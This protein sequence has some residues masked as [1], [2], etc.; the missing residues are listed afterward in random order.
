V[1]EQLFREIEARY[2]ELKNRVDQGKLTAD[3]FKQELKKM[4]I[5][6]PE[7]RYWMIGG[8]TGG[9][10]I[11][12]NNAWKTANPFKPV[13][14]KDLNH[15][16]EEEVQS[17]EEEKAT[18]SQ[19]QQA[20]VDIEK[21]GGLDDDA[22]AQSNKNDVYKYGGLD[23]SVKPT[24]QKE[25]VSFSQSEH[26]DASNTQTAADFYSKQSETKSLGVSDSVQ[27]QFD[28]E[29]DNHSEL[30]EG[31][32]IKREP[33]ATS[34]REGKTAAPIAQEE[35][36]KTVPCR[37]CGSQIAVFSQFCPICGGNQKKEPSKTQTATV[38]REGEMAI[39]SVHVLSFLIIFGVIG[40][41]F[42]LIVGAAFSI[43]EIGGDLIFQFP[44][45]MQDARGKMPGAFLFGGLGG[46]IGFFLFA[47]SGMALA[48][49]YNGIA[50]IFG[51]IRFKIRS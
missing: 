9:W 1:N 32:E 13:K 33:R 48:F 29:Q 38:P 3:S 20:Q 18:V 31:R 41:A 10:Y 36:A 28:S 16:H 30:K 14:Q 34:R 50:A 46:L 26:R 17:T 37:F 11:Y 15:A 44:Q 39:R 27:V 35:P 47:V 22:Q 5:Q 8:K 4:M 42:G 43:F 49:L 45:M 2:K 23:D 7:G 19:Q 25:P 24:T 12:E 6:D 51:G 21:Y 40:M